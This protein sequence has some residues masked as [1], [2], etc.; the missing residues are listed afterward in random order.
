MHIHENNG[1]ADDHQLPFSAKKAFDWKQLI[2]ALEEN[3]YQGIFNFEVM[4]E[5]NNTPL[6]VRHEKLKYMRYLAEYM[7]SDEFLN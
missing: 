3:N 7:L 2:R 4:G 5:S 1:K 6:A